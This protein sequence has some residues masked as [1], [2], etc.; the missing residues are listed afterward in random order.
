MQQSPF[1]EQE[2]SHKRTCSICGTNQTYVI[3]S[4]NSLLNGEFCRRRR[5]EC[6]YCKHR[7]T[8]K[9]VD[10]D[11]LDY[12]LI[13]EKKLNSFINGITTR[14]SWVTMNS[15]QSIACNKCLHSAGDRCSIGIPEYRSVE[16]V[17]CSAY[18]PLQPS[19]QHQWLVKNRSTAKTRA[20]P[21][22][23]NLLLLSCM[24][25]T[26]LSP[27]IHDWHNNFTGS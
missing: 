5:L 6:Q 4:R 1:T 7:S 2:N 18:T 17:D 3:E 10:S 11:F 12:L 8:T 19:W 16:A 25:S 24:S 20:L 14:D 27:T 21:Y 26:H 13:T 23:M 9:E 15:K 22:R